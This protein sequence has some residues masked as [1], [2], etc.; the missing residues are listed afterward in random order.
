MKPE[1]S[2]PVC[3]NSWYNRAHCYAELAV[4]SP[5]VAETIV[6]T[7]CADPRGWPGWV[8]LSGLGG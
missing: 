6:C 5:S 3:H 7:Y 2:K 4:S 1:Y 8:G